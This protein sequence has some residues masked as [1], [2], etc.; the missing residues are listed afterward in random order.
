[1]DIVDRILGPRGRRDPQAATKVMSYQARGLPQIEQWSAE[2]AYEKAYILD[3]FVFA[4]IRA[5]AQDV[6]SLPFRVADRVP[7]DPTE[8][9][10][11]NSK[12]PLALLLG[13]PPGGPSALLSAR[14]LW[15]W[16]VAQRMITGRMGWEI[17]YSKGGKV[18]ALWPLLSRLLAPIP[19]DGGGRWFDQFEYGTGPVRKRL[20]PE[21]VFYSWIPSQ[22][23]FRQSESPLQA[24]R[25]PID[26][27]VM[28]NK[29]DHAFI[30][31]DAVPAS[32]ITHQRIDDD[33]ARRSWR[34]RF[35]GRHG[36]PDN[37]GSVVFNEVEPDGDGKIVGTIAIERL[38]LT[39]SDAQF[40]QRYASSIQAICVGLGVPLSRLMDASGRTF[41]NAE[42]E[43]VNYWTSTIKPI[44]VELADDVNTQLAPRLGAGV[45]W[46]DMS[47][48][49]GLISPADRPYS[50]ADLPA[51]TRAGIV[52]QAWSAKQVGAPTQGLLEKP[53]H[54]LAE[55]FLSAGLNADGTP[56]PLALQPARE[57]IPQ[58]SEPPVKPTTV[59][60]VES[61]RQTPK[62]RVLERAGREAKAVPARVESTEKTWARAFNALF[63]RQAATALTRL[64]GS[65]GRQTLAAAKNIRAETFDASSVFDP[66]LWEDATRTLAVD[67]Y[68]SL[69]DSAALRVVELVSPDTDPASAMGKVSAALESRSNELAGQVTSTTYDAIRQQ[70]IEGAALGEGVDEIGRRIRG[71]FDEATTY[72]G[73]LI[74]RTEVNAAY[75]QAAL[76]AASE[77]PELVYGK[78]WLATSD[79][80]TR[81]EH[82]DADG[83]LRLLGQP[84]GVGGKSLD[85]PSEPNCR[86]TVL[87]LDQE[88][89]EA[90]S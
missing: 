70:L 21:Q 39:Q 77:F 63:E 31:N 14:K 42:G 75:N 82:L 9:Q 78:Q 85:A 19:A 16:S 66:G 52:S 72:R 32:M 59:M 76:V 88:E 15:A 22:N 34:Q 24:A 58:R 28:I 45:G 7:D 49:P 87:I 69:G 46:F 48:I 56:R 33:A 90:M 30:R 4:A 12:L 54:P 51:L 47:G 61:T 62:E 89:Y 26:L 73:K 43:Y 53:I 67:L 27:A 37:A 10:Q 50:L 35:L 64:K 17:E 3:A 6:A 79:S 84:F 86:C 71:V 1:M 38:G 18:T 83:Q 55:Q 41:S 20:A 13:P 8:E 44:T 36:G 65:R 60:V 68:T 2:Q 74:A 23:D 29:Y 80:R 57:I 25:I 40:A 81:R 11:Y 5:I